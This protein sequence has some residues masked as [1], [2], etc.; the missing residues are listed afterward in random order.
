VRK[1]LFFVGFFISLGMAM[2]GSSD[3]DSLVVV[4]GATINRTHSHFVDAD[5]I[6]ISQTKNAGSRCDSVAV[7]KDQKLRFRTLTE[8]ATDLGGIAG[9]SVRAAYKSDT[10]IRAKEAWLA[11]TAYYADSCFKADSCRIALR[12]HSADTSDTCKGGAARA[13]QWNGKS[14]PSTTTDGTL[15]NTAGTLSWNNLSLIYQ[16]LSSILTSVAALSGSS[17]GL[18]KLTNGTASLDATAYGTGSVT[19]VAMTVPTGLTISGS[20]ITTSGTLG[21]SLTSGYSIPTTA[22]QTNWSSAYTFTSGFT[23]NYPD[24]VAIEAL[25]GTAGFL[26]KTA[27]NTWALDNSTYLTGNQTITLSGDISGSGATSITMTLPTINSNV[28]TYQGITVNAKGQVTAAANQSYLTGNQTITLSGD[29][30]GS[31]TTAITATLANSGVTAGTY[32]A[33]TVSAKGLATSGTTICPVANGGT[34][35]SSLG[36]VGTAML[37]FTNL[38][39]G[40]LKWSG[41]ALSIDMTTYLTS[42]TGAPLIHG[43]SAGYIPYA[44]STTAWGNSPMYYNGT[45]IKLT[46]SY[47]GD[48]ASFIISSSGTSNEN[49]KY[50]GLSIWTQ[51]T[52]VTTP[53]ETTRLT[54]YWSSTTSE[55]TKFTIAQRG[56]GGN[57]YDVLT[58]L[59]S[60]STSAASPAVGIGTT[61]PVRADNAAVTFQ[62]GDR[63]VIQNTVGSQ[64]NISNNA[65]YDGTSWKYI[66]S[67]YAM[68]IRMNGLG[69]TGTTPGAITFT[70]SPSGA[71][72]ASITNHDGSDVRMVILNNGN[73]GIGTTSPTNGKLDVETTSGYAIYAYSSGSGT[74][75]IYGTATN[76]GAVGITGVGNSAGVWGTGT[77]Y[78]VGGEGN[79]GVYGSSSASNGTGGYFTNSNSTGGTG[80]YGSGFNYGVRGVCTSTSGYAG[81]FEGHT[82]RN[83]TVKSPSAAYTLNVASETSDVFVFTTAYTVTMGTGNNNGDIVYIVNASGSLFTLQGSSRYGTVYNGSCA[84]CTYYSGAWYIMFY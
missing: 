61:S 55:S 19:S 16:P 2:A 83:V 82:G 47:A 67:D 57:L 75:A 52:N 8:L 68:S 21:L 65:Y 31:G 27:T 40:F 18:I 43:C 22:N 46:D 72:G 76:S 80:I 4:G 9:D 36:T 11:F 54:S 35:L 60:A 70:C 37:A 42:A 7:I 28:G 51:S 62:I 24:L 73:V 14:M 12:A 79:V 45:N 48:N 63:N 59:G 34:G 32:G 20:P 64:T 17:T 66:V 41:S 74:S 53:Y 49:G 77:T 15:Y 50:R 78:G 23:T 33:L 44:T 1:L 25:T 84:A 39:A 38:N 5:S 10:T 26:K 71:A 30:S 56:Y 29:V 13:V 69:N 3:T 6:G 81:Y 58:I